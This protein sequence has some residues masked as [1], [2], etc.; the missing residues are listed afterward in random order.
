LTA[1]TQAPSSN[2]GKEFAHRLRIRGSLTL[3]LAKTDKNCL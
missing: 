1:G 3:C 2:S